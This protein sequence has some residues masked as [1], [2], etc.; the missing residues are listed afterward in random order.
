[1][2]C[3]ANFDGNCH[4]PRFPLTR[5]VPT[6]P[7]RPLQRSGRTD[8]QGMKRASA[9]S[10]FKFP[11][12][13]F[14]PACATPFLRNKTF[15]P[16][17][18]MRKRKHYIIMWHARHVCSPLSLSLSL[19]FPLSVVALHS[20]RAPFLRAERKMH[21][22]IRISNFRSGSREPPTLSSSP[23]SWGSF[24]PTSCRAAAATYSRDMMEK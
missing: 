17:Q 9:P 18:C 1:M 6:L 10:P 8:G 23:C 21:G 14:F 2:Q 22:E 13:V 4:L 3:V 16:P 12:A 19:P 11:S 5:V 20:H 7:T 15:P 24:A